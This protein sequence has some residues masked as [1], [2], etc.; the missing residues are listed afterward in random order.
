MNAIEAI[1]MSAVTSETKA[2]GTTRKVTFLLPNDGDHP[3]AGMVGERLHIVCLKI[4]DDETTESEARSNP[5]RAST[6]EDAGAGDTPPAAPASERGPCPDCG[7]K[8]GYK[9]EDGCARVRR[10]WDELPPTAQA[11]I[12]CS[13]PDFQR[14]A[15]RVADDLGWTVPN[16]PEERAESVVR[17]ICGIASRRELNS[18]PTA[19][20]RWQ[21]LDT[22]FLQ[23]TGKLPWKAA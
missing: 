14:Y 11:G 4:N 23:A 12:R 15:A 16:D 13:D 19:A 20:A 8:H 9:H 21:R 17:E 1:V 18:H 7:A 6:S 2:N 22:E 5:P 3:F 10:K